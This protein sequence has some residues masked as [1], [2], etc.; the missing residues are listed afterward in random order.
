M[1]NYISFKIPL[2][3]VDIHKKFRQLCKDYPKI[4]SGLKTRIESYCQDQSHPLYQDSP[5]DF[6]ER[7][8]G[9]IQQICSAIVD[10]INKTDHKHYQHLL[11][12]IKS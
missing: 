11:N 10:L 2:G 6:D 3:G 4:D 1:E 7:L 8:L 12:A 5:T 9:E